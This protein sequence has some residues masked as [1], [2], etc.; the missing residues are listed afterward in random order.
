M[1]ETDILKYDKK[2]K[3]IDA[4][5][6]RVRDRESKQSRTKLVMME[7]MMDAPGW[8]DGRTGGCGW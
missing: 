4:E 3:K 7:A 2:K 5:R 1:W 6:S 8:V